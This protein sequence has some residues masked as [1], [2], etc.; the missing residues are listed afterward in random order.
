M[1]DFNIGFAFNRQV[2]RNA[3]VRWG[4]LVI[5]EITAAGRND[6]THSSPAEILRKIPHFSSNGGDFLAMQIPASDN[7]LSQAHSKGIKS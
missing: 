7:G 5:I 4:E 3:N 6:L 1:L 2:F